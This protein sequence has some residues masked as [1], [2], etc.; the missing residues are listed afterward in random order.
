MILKG[1]GS[2]TPVTSSLRRVPILVNSDQII[3][4]VIEEGQRPAVS[5]PGVLAIGAPLAFLQRDSGYASVYRP[6][7]QQSSAPSL[8]YQFLFGDGGYI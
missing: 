4:Y 8:F 5:V 3:V 1:V 2:G 6:K 7:E